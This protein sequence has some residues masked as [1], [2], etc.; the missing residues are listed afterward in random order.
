MARKIAKKL[1][2]PF[3]D[4]LKKNKKNKPQKKMETTLSQKENLDGVFK[5][6][7]KRVPKELVPKQ[8]VH[9]KVAPRVTKVLLPGCSSESLS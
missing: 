7:K 6:I 9:N 1:K 8:P 5:V 4:C 2:L 3:V